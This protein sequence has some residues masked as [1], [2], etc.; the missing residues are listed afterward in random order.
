[1]TVLDA[2][3]GTALVL[4]YAPARLLEKAIVD[5]EL[6]PTD[7]YTVS[8]QE[9]V[10][11]AAVNALIAAKSL[12]RASQ[13]DSSFQLNHEQANKTITYLSTRNGGFGGNQAVADI[14]AEINGVVP[15]VTDVSHLW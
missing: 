9:K 3:I 8:M 1:M 14:L 13:G 15:T 5:A 2:L 6:E 7:S 10:D 4:E 11:L 12:D